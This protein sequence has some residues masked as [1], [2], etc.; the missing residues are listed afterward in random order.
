M[1]GL[2]VRVG[3]GVVEPRCGQRGSRIPEL[4]FRYF[5]PRV[6]SHDLSVSGTMKGQE[7]FTLH[8]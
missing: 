1:S 8:G 7:G 3:G 6:T 5:A 4:D 2:V